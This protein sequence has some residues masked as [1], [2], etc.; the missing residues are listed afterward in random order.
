MRSRA[1]D[2]SDGETHGRYAVSDDAIFD[3]V[4]AAIVKTFRP[5][6][7]VR[8]VPSTTRSD[9]P[10]WDSLSHTMLVMSIED[11]FG[12]ELPLDELDGLPDVGAL[13]ELVRRTVAAR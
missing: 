5:G 4:A 10:R 6:G 8:I 9:V 11:E 1:E 3:R 7:D 12:I 13:V 2:A